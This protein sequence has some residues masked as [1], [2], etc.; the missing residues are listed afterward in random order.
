MP[1]D[2]QYDEENEEE[3]PHQVDPDLLNEDDAEEVEAVTN[4]HGKARKK[5]GRPRKKKED[6]RPRALRPFV[7]SGPLQI[8]AKDDLADM[9]NRY[10]WESGEYDA[11]LIRQQPQTWKHRNVHGYIAS[12]THPVDE[13]FIRGNFGGGVYDIR[14]RGPHPRTGKKGFL[15]GGRV[16]ISGDPVI[17]PLEKDLDGRDEAEISPAMNI[18]PHLNEDNN[19]SYKWMERRE[20]E[21]SKEAKKL[22]ERLFEE[23]LKSKDDGSTTDKAMQYIQEST[24]RAI[25][26]ERRSAERILEEQEKTRMEFDRLTARMQNSGIPPEMLQTLTEQH[27]SEMN[28]L[29]ES[30]NVQIQQTHDRSEHEIKSLRERYEREIA[31]L[32][33]KMQERI[34]RAE[35]Q[36]RRELDRNREESD[37]RY[38]KLN[39]EWQRRI[40]QEKQGTRS[41]RESFERHNSMQVEHM[42]SLHDSQ[43]AQERSQHESSS[44]QIKSQYES[45]I[46]MQET[47]LQARIDSMTM[48]LER[49]RADLSVAQTKVQDQGDLAT[50]AKK[51][52]DVNE[53]LGAVFGLGAA[54]GKNE[55]A[56]VDLEPKQEEPK[57]WWGKLMQFADSPMGEGTF[58]FIKNM[59]AGAS[60]MYPPMMP[61]LPGGQQPPMYAPPPGYGPPQP[62][63]PQQNYAP[64]P[65]APYSSVYE[66]EEAG[67]AT[68]HFV[69]E[70]AVE[71]AG[72]VAEAPQVQEAP[73]APPADPTHGAFGGVAYS[74]GP[75]ISPEEVESLH[76]QDAQPKPQPPLQQQPQEI[77]QEAVEQ[78]KGMINGLEESM[79]TNVQPHT[80]AQTIMKMAPRQQVEGMAQTSLAQFVATIQRIAPDS[81]LLTFQG[82]KYLTALQQSLAQLLQQTPA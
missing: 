81:M 13:D 46:K 16:K 5:R 32:Q 15:T 42:K 74:K 27:R 53:S 17:S 33:D 79:N 6:D 20:A 25:D 78:L 71:H 57:T 66:P 80:L 18:A 45:Q 38:D 82:R 54:V 77:P 31:N 48:E 65:Q 24:K 29:N 67:T 69:E 8:M 30:R 39:E 56:D 51:I 76:N 1:E 40:D 28:A 36:Y 72:P 12:F 62:Q 73:P 10:D 3:Q 11:L 44:V 37:R 9:I 50:Q 4:A 34:D 41:D 52:R 2:D 59:A 63:P 35:D 58:D 68:G 64:P 75:E 61:G 49:V 26:A 19:S 22:R 23:A 7:E 43:V 14:I 55:L 70:E 21:A 47:S 60:G